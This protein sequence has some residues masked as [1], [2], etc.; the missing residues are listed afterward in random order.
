MLKKVLLLA[1]I[2]LQIGIFS[3]PVAQADAA[4]EPS[5]FPC[6]R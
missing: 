1:A 2:L 3:V 5:C 6:S 4:P